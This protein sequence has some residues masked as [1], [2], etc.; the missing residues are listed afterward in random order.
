LDAG[1]HSSR[2]GSSCRRP[3]TCTEED[4]DN[5]G[6]HSDSPYPG[7][8]PDKVPNLLEEEEDGLLEPKGAAAGIAKEAEGD[9]DQDEG[10]GAGK[11]RNRIP[12][13]RSGGLSRGRENPRQ[14]LVG[15]LIGQVI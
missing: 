6:R 10:D 3:K 1:R 7:I 13:V 4:K 8:D 5:R 14:S 11:P 15:F 9:P 2:K 12:H